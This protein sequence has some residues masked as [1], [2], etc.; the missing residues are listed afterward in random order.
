MRTLRAADGETLHYARNGEGPPVVMLHGWTASHAEWSPLVRALS[1][2][3]TVIRWDARGHGGPGRAVQSAPTAGRMADDLAALLAHESVEAATLV[4]HSMGALTAWEYF[5]RHGGAR[6]SRVVLVDQ[7]PKLLT[8]AGWT[9]GIYGDFDEAR[10]RAF[11]ADLERDFAE[12]V[13]RLAAY[14]LNPHARGRY[15]AGS[16]GWAF[17]R[18]AL[19]RLEP[20]PLIACWRSL[21]AGDW[22]DVLPRMGVPA[23]L[24]HG[25]ASNFYGEDTAR[26]VHSR[27]PGSHLE[28][29][30]MADH[31]PHLAAPERFAR[32]VLAFSTGCP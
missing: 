10:S 23:L 11:L 12:S 16:R 13:L 31:S 26:E 32:E 5:R 18:E 1:A 27:I 30:P 7:S 4:G 25:G 24:V 15:E 17:A 8:D 20:A 22:R 9:H 28:I 6:I 14:G 29:Y 3:R 2:E 21:V 19:R